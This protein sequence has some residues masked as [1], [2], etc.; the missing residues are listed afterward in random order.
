MKCASN[1]YRVLGVLSDESTKKCDDDEQFLY[2]EDEIGLGG[3]YDDQTIRS[4]VED[5]STLV[6]QPRRVGSKLFSLT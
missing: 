2:D 5:F 6:S 4:D 3:Q 1:S